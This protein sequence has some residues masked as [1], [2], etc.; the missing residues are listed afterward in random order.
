LLGAI[1]GGLG[2]YFGPQVTPGGSIFSGG[3]F[4]PS[5]TPF[6]NF[7]GATQGAGANTSSFVDPMSAVNAGT[8]VVQPVAG[9]GFSP[10]VN[11]MTSAGSS[12]FMQTLGRGAEGDWLFPS[13]RNDGPIS[14]QAIADRFARWGRQAGVHL[15][16]HRLRHSHATSAIRSGCDPF[17]LQLTLGH[18]SAA[19]TAGSVAANP[20]DSSS[21]RLG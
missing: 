10:S 15:H 12:P 7:G 4:D 11:L 2:G 8:A 9:A 20:S 6:S 14:R 17:T 13:C 19:T 21:L 18:S 16:P 3:V 5:T 1:G